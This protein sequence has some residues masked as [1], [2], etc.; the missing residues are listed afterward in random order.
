MVVRRRAEHLW[1][2]TTSGARTGCPAGRWGYPCFRP[3]RDPARDPHHGRR[4]PQRAHGPPLVT[5]TLAEH[6]RRRFAGERQQ[7]HRQHRHSSRR[8]RSALTAGGTNSVLRDRTPSD[9]PLREQGPHDT[10]RGTSY[11]T[12]TVATAG[13]YRFDMDGDSSYDTMIVPLQRH[14]DTARGTAPMR[15]QL[16]R[17]PAFHRTH[18]GRRRLHAAYR[19]AQQRPRQLSAGHLPGPDRQRPRRRRRHQW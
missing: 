4:E 16:V 17:H 13:T 10:S 19:R 15:P 5:V 11:V 7:R 14:R 3:E 8:H 18:I 6:R 12:F 9:R 2:A 1:D